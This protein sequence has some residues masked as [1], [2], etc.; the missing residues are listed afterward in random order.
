VAV[1]AFVRGEI[2]FG[3]IAE[4][5]ADALA[6]IEPAPLSLAAV[7][8]ADRQARVV[9]ETLVHERSVN[10]AVSAGAPMK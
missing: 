6:R 7:R 5:I 10:P 2:R 8:L 9:A 1:A 4:V 3:E